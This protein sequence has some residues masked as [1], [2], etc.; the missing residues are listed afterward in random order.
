MSKDSETQS[1][2]SGGDHRKINNIGNLKPEDAERLIQKMRRRYHGK[3][4]ALE[5]I[6]IYDPKSSYMQKMTE[7]RA[8]LKRDNREAE[9]KIEEWLKENYPLIS[10][11]L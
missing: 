5:E 8:V 3:P 2:L 9:L 1:G 4:L 6:D 10:S 7:Y 11:E